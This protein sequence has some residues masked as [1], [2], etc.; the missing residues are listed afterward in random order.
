M[1]NPFGLKLLC[2]VFEWEYVDDV[3]VS[4]RF[5]RCAGRVPTAEFNIWA[6]KCEKQARKG[7]GV[8][9]D[10]SP[11]YL[12][13]LLCSWVTSP[14]RGWGGGEGVSPDVPLH[15][16]RRGD[17]GDISLSTAHGTHMLKGRKVTG[18]LRNKR[19]KPMWER[20]WCNDDRKVVTEHRGEKMNTVGGRCSDSRK[21]RKEIL[22][23]VTDNTHRPM[24]SI[25][26]ILYF[27][28]SFP[29]QSEQL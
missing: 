1:C 26:A 10:R 19:E 15:G 24:W 8:D 3:F 6:P 5:E 4:V 29:P 13:L 9:P 25:T 11:H 7:G 12:F 20:P 22:K 2:G 27:F 14:E 23:G 16:L 18:Y 28:F 21:M 17:R